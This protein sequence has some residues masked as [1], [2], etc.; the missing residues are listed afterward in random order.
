MNGRDSVEPTS[1]GH[2]NPTGSAPIRR[3][4]APGHLAGFVRHYWVPEWAL[5]DGRVVTAR[6]LGYP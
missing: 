2:L 3:Y 5:P 4:R 6:V 1:K